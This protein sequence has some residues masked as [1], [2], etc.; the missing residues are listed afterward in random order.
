MIVVI[1]HLDNLRYSLAGLTLLLLLLAAS[2]QQAQA[3]EKLPPT[4]TTDHKA[5]I[6]KKKERPKK[7]HYMTII[8]TDT[9]NILYGNKCF[10]DFTKKLGFIYD[11]QPKKAPGSMN[12]FSRFWHNAAVKTALVFTAWPW[13]RLRVKKKY[14]ECREYSG[15]FVG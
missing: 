4:N 12:G 14:K 2:G 3:Q 6:N 5:R 9:K 8:K 13:W 15:D 10:E 7:K 11:I 1:K